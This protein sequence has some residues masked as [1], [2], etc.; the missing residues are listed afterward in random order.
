M[1]LPSICSE[2]RGWHVLPLA[3]LNLTGHRGHGHC[4]IQAWIKKLP[5]FLHSLAYPSNPF[6]CSF[7]YKAATASFNIQKACLQHTWLY[8]NRPFVCSAQCLTEGQTLGPAG[9]TIVGPV[10]FILL[11]VR[12]LPVYPCALCQIGYHGTINKAMKRVSINRE[13]EI[14]F[15]SMM[16]ILFNRKR[17]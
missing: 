2:W 11:M 6:S 4:L 15:I 5:L 12:A 16:K 10:S 14:Y 1:K 13:S 17:E 7:F 8:S 9:P 3:L